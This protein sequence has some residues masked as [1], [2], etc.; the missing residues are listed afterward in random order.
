MPSFSIKLMR[1]IK[2]FTLFSPVILF[3][4]LCTVLVSSFGVKLLN[5]NFQSEVSPPGMC[6]SAAIDHIEMGIDEK[7]WLDAYNAT[8]RK[9]INVDDSNHV[10]WINAFDKTKNINETYASLK[11]DATQLNVSIIK[12]TARVIVSTNV[13]IV[14]NPSDNVSEISYY[15]INLNNGSWINLG[16]ETSYSYT[17]LNDGNYTV[18]VKAVDDVGNTAEASISF[19]VLTA[20]ATGALVDKWWF[21]LALAAVTAFLISAALFMKRRNVLGQTIKS[22]NGQAG[23]KNRILLK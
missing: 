23:M 7:T 9:F 20:P 6:T 16:N 15:E 12:P 10:V 22:D 1:L 21:W 3:L 18:Y 2:R 8:S 19:T 13:T 4:L 5:E 11:A 14:W 17:E